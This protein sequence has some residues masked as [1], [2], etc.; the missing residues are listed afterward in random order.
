MKKQLIP[1]LKTYLFI[2]IS[3]FIISLIMAT[4]CTLIHI[5]SF[6]YQII[7]QLISYLLLI[8]SCLFLFK[9]EQNKPVIHGFIYAISY[10][11]ISFIIHIDSLSWTILIKPLFI[12][13]I[14]CIFSY[15]KKNNND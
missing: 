5:S 1:Y 2:M 4:L 7:I 13:I 15:I 11:L 10:L 12:F 14:F 6:I 3:Y 9:L 8:I